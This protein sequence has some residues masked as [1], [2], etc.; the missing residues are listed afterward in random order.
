MQKPF[1]CQGCG[2]EK[3]ANL[4]LKG[5]Q[6][7]CGEPRCQ[8]ARKAQ[9]QKTKMKTDAVY[10][11]QEL[12]CLREWRRKRPLHRYQSEYRETHPEYVAENRR[13]QRIRNWK[14]HRQNEAEMIVKMDALSK[15]KSNTYVMRPLACEKIVKMDALV[16]ELT[17]LQHVSS[18]PGPSPP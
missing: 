11:A 3:Q 2:Q 9:W 7:F 1:I 13:K 17:V 14:R 15:I 6:G 10:R 8:R 18:H 4:R 5:N 12:D 16:V